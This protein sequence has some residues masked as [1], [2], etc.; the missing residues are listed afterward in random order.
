MVRAN[1]FK[2]RSVR[3]INELE[4]WIFKAETG[5]M[6]HMTGAHDDTI[7]CLAMGLFVMR[8][9]LNKLQDVKNK[10]AAI[11]SAYM[12][13]GSAKPREERR[14]YGQSIDIH[15]KEMVLPFYN[16]RILNKSR[17]NGNMMWLYTV[18]Q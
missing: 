16:R 9:S 15:P 5:R 1:E 2:I 8:Y 18:N 17:I 12:T 3:V 4:T 11:L 6:D 10:D 7:T 14:D 13:G